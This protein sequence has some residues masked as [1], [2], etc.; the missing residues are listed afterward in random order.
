MFTTFE[1]KALDRD[2]SNI[3]SRPVNKQILTGSQ[4]ERVREWILIRALFPSKSLLG[5]F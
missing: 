2:Q 5:Y 1:I 3:L 4:Q